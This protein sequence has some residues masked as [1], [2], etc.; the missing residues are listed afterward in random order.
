MSPCA[1]LAG[2]AIGNGDAFVAATSD[3]GMLPSKACNSTF[4]FQ[5]TR[6]LLGSA[7]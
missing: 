6:P 2:D 3:H 7:K 5:E 4:Q 1:Q